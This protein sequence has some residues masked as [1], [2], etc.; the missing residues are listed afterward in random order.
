MKRV[1]AGMSLG[2]VAVLVIALIVLSQT[3]YSPRQAALQEYLQPRSATVTAMMQANKSQNFSAE[4]STVV[5]QSVYFRTGPWDGA[6]TL[7]FP[8]EEVWCALLHD[9][10]GDH[11]VFVVLH[12]DLYNAQWLVH[13]PKV[14]WPDVALKAQL[15][16]IGCDLPQ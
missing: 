14:K 16:A 12:S 5:G 7:P 6:R 8:P 13:E 4:M 15:S 11:I 1:V 3:L 2:L 10:Q 9:M